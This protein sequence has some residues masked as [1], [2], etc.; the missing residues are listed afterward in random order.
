MSLFTLDEIIIDPKS[1]D[2][3]M[4]ACPEQ[5]LSGIVGRLTEKLVINRLVEE[6]NT[7]LEQNF[8][9]V[10]GR[11]V[12]V[13]LLTGIEVVTSK[14]RNSPLHE[15]DAMVRNE[16]TSYVVEV[17]SGGLNGYSSK[18]ER[19][20]KLGHTFNPNYK[21]LILVL[22][23]PYQYRGTL[24]NLERTYPNLH[25]VNLRVNRKDLLKRANKILHS[26]NFSKSYINP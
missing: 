5:S 8:P 9:K 4:L 20:L 24:H 13:K 25:F 11:Y 15:F 16:E 17:K 3:E 19:A 2:G 23:F 18:I 7:V 10:V 14:S 12:F 1:F 6:P 21:G 22:P 26:H